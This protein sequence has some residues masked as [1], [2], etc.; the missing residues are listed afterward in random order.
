VVL[1]Q[2]NAQLKDDSAKVED[3]PLIILQKKMAEMQAEADTLKRLNSDLEVQK[4]GKPRVA[5]ACAS[6]T[7]GSKVTCFSIESERD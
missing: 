7:M 6:D 3:S 4:G 2:V 1:S 5:L